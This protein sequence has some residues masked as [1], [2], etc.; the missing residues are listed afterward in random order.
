VDIAQWPQIS[1]V[2]E[3]LKKLEVY[4]IAHANNQVDAVK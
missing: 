3:N 2:F 1:E 4:D